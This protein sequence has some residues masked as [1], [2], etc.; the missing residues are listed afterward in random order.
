MRVLELVLVV[1]L[2]GGGDICQPLTAQWVGAGGYPQQNGKTPPVCGNPRWPKIVAHNRC[3]IYGSNK[4]FK[5]WINKRI[6]VNWIVWNRTVWS[7]NC[8]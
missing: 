6:M 5:L 8:V 3:P 1:F 7:F 4:T 2:W